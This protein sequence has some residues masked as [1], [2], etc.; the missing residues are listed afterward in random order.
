MIGTHGKAGDQQVLSGAVDL[1]D[2]GQQ[3]L[4]DVVV[5]GL[6]AADP[7]VRVA[8]HQRNGLGVDGVHGEQLE[9]AALQIVSQGVQHAEALPVI[10][11]AVLAG[12]DQN[13]L[14][15]VAVDLKFHIPAQ[16]GTVFLVIFRVHGQFLLC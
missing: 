16:A 6:V 11:A 12:K 13:R 1:A 4:H 10:E 2:A 3:L 8:V 14:S 9:L 5:P 15:A 7:G